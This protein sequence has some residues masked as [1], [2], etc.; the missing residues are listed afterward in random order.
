MTLKDRLLEAQKNI[1]LALLRSGRAQH[2]EIV[3]ATKTRDPKTIN[4]TI[5]CGITNIGENRI[6]EAEKKFGSFEKMPQLKKTKDFKLFLGVALQRAKKFS[7]G[8]ES[9]KKAHFKADAGERPAIRGHSLG[10]KPR[11][12]CFSQV[13]SCNTF[14]HN[15]QHFPDVCCWFGDLFRFALAQAALPPPS[16]SISIEKTR[17][18][19]Q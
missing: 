4:E 9:H 12:W 3:A 8:S 6:Q 18:K 1:D 17:N 15:L 10:L 14:Q 5:Q 16:S 2:V 13:S 19:F 7:A 11:V